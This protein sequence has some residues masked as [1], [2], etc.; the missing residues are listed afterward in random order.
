MTAFP[1]LYGF[2][3]S[4][5]PL[6]SIGR[7]AVQKREARLRADDPA[8]F[9]VMAGL[10]PT[11]QVFLAW[12]SLRH[13]GQKRSVLAPDVPAIHVPPLAYQERRWP[14]QAMTRSGMMMAR[15]LVD[16]RDIG[17]KRVFATMFRP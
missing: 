16:Q 17:A 2:S 12:F 9:F 7:H 15:E 1:V 3:G 8:T 6:K 5:L 4:V 14:G 10:D 13:A 11:I